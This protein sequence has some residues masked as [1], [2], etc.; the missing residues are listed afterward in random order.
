MGLTIIEVVTMFFDVTMT[1]HS[2]HRDFQISGETNVNS[3]LVS[4][5]L[6]KLDKSIYVELTVT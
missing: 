5:Y 6:K 4:K 3:I 2:K 1:W